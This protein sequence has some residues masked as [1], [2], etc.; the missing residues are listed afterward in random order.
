MIVERLLKVALL[1]SSWVMYM[2]LGLSVISIGAAIERWW[3]FRKHRNGDDLGDAL[4]AKLEAGDSPGAEKLLATHGSIEASIIQRAI[5]W[6]EGGPD[7]LADSIES[8][9]VKKR[10]ELERGMT[11][12]GTLGNNAPFIGLFGTVI[13]VIEAFHQLGAG[14]DKTAMG[15][16]MNGIA[17]ALVATGVGLFVA[18][19]AV[20]AFNIFQKKIGDVEGNVDAI[21][22]QLSA[23]LK[24]AKYGRETG[25]SIAPRPTVETES[26]TEKATPMAE[27]VATSRLDETPQQ[28]ALAASRVAEGA[29]DGLE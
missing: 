7:A 10:K 22:K 20:V 1:G 5:R 19:P 25:K 28:S 2:L 9:L 27:R 18:I 16:V 3:F 24:A 11:L 4:C 21:A 17:E 12:L 13:G 8:E 6:V 14:Q 15:N 23:L 26:E 29:W